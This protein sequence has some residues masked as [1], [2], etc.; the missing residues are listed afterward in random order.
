MEWQNTQAEIKKISQ[1]I[2]R[3]LKQ[4]YNMININKNLYDPKSLVSAL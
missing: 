4:F 1:C 3:H 2:I